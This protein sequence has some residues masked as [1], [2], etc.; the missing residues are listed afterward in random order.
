MDGIDQIGTTLC[1]PTPGKS[2]MK[3]SVPCGGRVSVKSPEAIRKD[4]AEEEGD[5]TK[6]DLFRE[7]VRTP[8]VALRSTSRRQ[9]S[10]ARKTAEET[11]N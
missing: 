3:P 2:A 5:E 10:T 1:L 4:A 9:R 7:I 11:G 8:G 6:R